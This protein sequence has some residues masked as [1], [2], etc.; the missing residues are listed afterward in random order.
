MKIIVLRLPAPLCAKASI[1]CSTAI[2]RRSVAIEKVLQS[3][4]LLDTRGQTYYEREAPWGLFCH[5]WSDSCKI[6]VSNDDNNDDD[7]VKIQC[8]GIHV[9]GRALDFLPCA[10]SCFGLRP[11]KW[12]FDIS[13]FTLIVEAI[14]KIRLYLVVATNH[15]FCKLWNDWAQCCSFVKSSQS[16]NCNIRENGKELASHGSKNHVKP[17]PPP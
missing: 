8:P 15:K 4:G 2:T 12:G 14:D 1:Y 5:F 7:L 6:I 13:L 10:H 9:N 11:Q 17:P 16:P 3:H